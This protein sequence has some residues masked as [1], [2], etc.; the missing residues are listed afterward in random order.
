[1][2]FKIQHTTRYTY[3]APVSDNHNELRLMPLTDDRQTCT[4]F[5]LVT[6]PLAHVFYYNLPTGRVH[7]FNIRAPHKSLTVT[8]TAHIVTQPFD[9]FLDLPMGQNDWEFYTRDVTRED[10]AEYLVPTERVPLD[11]PTGNLT[12]IAD[13]A[14]E[15]ESAADFLISLNRVLH[16]VLKYHPGATDVDTPLAEVIA[17]HTG[18]CQDFA[19]LMLAICRSRNIPARYVS[20]YLYT[21]GTSRQGVDV[22]AD[23]AE[24]ALSGLGYSETPVAKPDAAAQLV[25]GGAMHAWVECLLPDNRWHGFD[26]TNCLLT[27][28]LYIRVHTGRDYGDVPPMHGV[29]SGPT[30]TKLEVSVAVTPE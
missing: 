12:E 21:Q 16:R 24:T 14:T 29:Y 26:P 8:A 1:M 28:E 25:D 10:Y 4:D 9:P 7:H 23:R 18:V 22:L 20:G 27:N 13:A 5:W 19:H 15:G 2:R 17:T 6:A 30:A 11:L 3:P